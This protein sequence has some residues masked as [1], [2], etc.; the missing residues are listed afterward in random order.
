MAFEPFQTFGQNRDGGLRLLVERLFPSQGP[1]D[2]LTIATIHPCL[3][4]P[5]RYLE[6]LMLLLQNT[7][8]SL[9]HLLLILAHVVREVLLPII[10]VP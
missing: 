5:T 8:S 1:G 2:N 9:G 3:L 10:T 6:F 4:P 7:L